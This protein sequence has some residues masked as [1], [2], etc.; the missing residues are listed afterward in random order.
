M[1]GF[2]AESG[3]RLPGL[4][5]QIAGSEESDIELSYPIVCP[6]SP[7]KNRS[8]RFAVL[9]VVKPLDCNQI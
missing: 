7:E 6:I 2:V 3:G 8:P 9:A 1:H 4:G 5:I